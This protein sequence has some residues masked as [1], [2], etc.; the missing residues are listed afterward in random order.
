MSKYKESNIAPLLFLRLK[1][2]WR[3]YSEESIFER[4]TDP[5]TSI[6][7]VRSHLQNERQSTAT[8]AP[9]ARSTDTME[10]TTNGAEEGLNTSNQER[11]E[12]QT[13]KS[14]PSTGGRPTILA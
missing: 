4:R 13:P 9:L 8:P 11:L 10:N 12:E 7:M 3:N 6:E 1:F 2:V 5:E 14:R